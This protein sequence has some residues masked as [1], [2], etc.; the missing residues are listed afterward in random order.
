MPRSSRRA[1]QC[2]K[3]HCDSAA[4]WDVNLTFLC[5]GMGIYRRRLTCNSTVKVCGKHREEAMEY[6]LSPLNRSRI[7]VWAIQNNYPPPDFETA[8]FDFNRVDHDAIDLALMD[9]TEAEAQ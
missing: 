2:H 4:T 7:T 1:H 3:D 5:K 8:E 9:T 6:I